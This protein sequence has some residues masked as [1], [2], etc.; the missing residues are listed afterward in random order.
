MT[1]RYER[2]AR[3]APGWGCAP[4]SLEDHHLCR[5]A[6]LRPADRALCARRPDQLRVAQGLRRTGAGKTRN[7]SSHAEGN[8]DRKGILR[9]GRRR[10]ERSGTIDHGHA[11]GVEIGFAA[12]PQQGN[13]RDPARFIENKPDNRN[14]LG[15]ALARGLWILFHP[16]QHPA[17]GE[18]MSYSFVAGCGRQRHRDGA[19]TIWPRI[20]GW[21]KAGCASRWCL[22]PPFWRGPPASLAARRCPCAISLSTMSLRAGFARA[23]GPCVADGCGAAGFAMGLGPNIAS[24]AGLGFAGLGFASVSSICRGSRLGAGVASPGSAGLFS[25][26]A[27][28]ITTSIGISRA[29]P[30]RLGASSRRTNASNRPPCASTEAAVILARRQRR[31]GAAAAGLGASPEN[32]LRRSGAR[33]CSLLL[34]SG[35]ESVLKGCLL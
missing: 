25:G 17:D 5:R 26:G 2:P 10:R 34:R 15:P 35:P 11:F 12:R 9:A 27:G 29:G 8:F 18:A 28:S 33:F 24:F 6:A 32:R 19:K 22:L 13:R 1:R 14:P 21:R 3:P 23:P 4:W 16:S 31:S 20:E 7:L 30:Q